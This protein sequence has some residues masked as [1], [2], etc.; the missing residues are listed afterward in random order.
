MTLQTELICLNGNEI[1]QGDTS[2]L[3]RYQLEAQGK[4][5]EGSA[6]IQLIKKD[7][8]CYELNADVID[9]LLEFKFSNIL[10][11]GLYKIEIEIGGYVFPSKDTEYI[12]V[13]QNYEVALTPA[14][15][16]EKDSAIKKAVSEAMVGYKP[17]FDLTEIVAQIKEQLP[18]PT[19][20]IPS[21]VSQV[22]AQLPT[23][24]K[25]ERGERGEVGPQGLKGEQG[26]TGPRGERG[27]K[28][29]TGPQGPK[30]ERG[31]T[32]PRGERG[33]QGSNGLTQYIHFA[34]ADNENG[35]GFS[36]NNVGKTCLGFYVDLERADSNIPS[37]Y[38]WVRIKGNDANTDELKADIKKIEKYTLIQ[39]TNAVNYNGTPTV[40]NN[41]MEMTYNPA[42]GIGII[43][44]DFQ[45]AR[46]QVAPN[47]VVF[48]LPD[49]APT[50]LAYTEVAGVNLR[51][52]MGGH[53]RKIYAQG[54]VGVRE[55]VNIV[56]FF[57]K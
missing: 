51:C 37:K 24:P 35:G 20:D 42:T 27:E 15:L 5:V 11:V 19:I 36:F 56:A 8:V 1:K 14:E 54:P 2:S 12:Y 49:N 18:Q 52:F 33:E 3:F 16:L 17:T 40:D 55:V 57:G 48:Y 44:L 32:G 6:K 7:K 41:R 31:E 4:E 50:P 26:S 46:T 23:G 13:N 9:N 22:L 53:E 30:G 28:G 21:I 38:R 25:G 45:K 29:D 10:E 39:Y 34:F 47:D 43:H